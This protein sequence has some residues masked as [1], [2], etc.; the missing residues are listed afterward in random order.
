MGSESQNDVCAITA[1]V[2]NGA[3]K[4]PVSLRDD[5]MTAFSVFMNTDCIVY[6]Y[7]ETTLGIFF[8]HIPPSLAVKNRLANMFK[9]VRESFRDAEESHIEALPTVRMAAS[10]VFGFL[11]T[12]NFD[13]ATL[14]AYEMALDHRSDQIR[15][16]ADVVDNPL[17]LRDLTA[18][19]QSVLEG[20]HDFPDI[21]SLG[22][23]ELVA[24]AESLRAMQ[25]AEAPSQAIYVAL[26]AIGKYYRAR[27]TYMLMMPKDDGVMTVL[28]EWTAPSVASI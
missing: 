24:Y 1:V 5:L 8:P 14:N 3:A 4:F 6:L 20:I 10:T 21:G 12:F 11:K 26:Q 18:S 25:D 27:R 17:A 16:I 22:R 2:F 7:N 9:A 13:V 19:Q 28:Y 15:E 23:E